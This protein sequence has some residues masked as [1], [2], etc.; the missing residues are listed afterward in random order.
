M[1]FGQYNLNSTASS[2]THIIGN[3]KSSGEDNPTKTSSSPFR[4]NKIRLTTPAFLSRFQ[5]RIET[6]RRLNSRSESPISFRASLFDCDTT[7]RPTSSGSLDVKRARNTVPQ[8][9]HWNAIHQHLANSATISRPTSPRSHHINITHNYREDNFY[10]FGAHTRKIGFKHPQPILTGRNYAIPANRPKHPTPP[11]SKLPFRNPIDFHQPNDTSLKHI[12]D[13]STRIGEEIEFKVLKDYFETTSYSEIV[14]DPDFKDYL[15][16]KNYGDIL[17]YLDANNEPDL[18]EVSSLYKEPNYLQPRQMNKSKSTG[19][20]YDSVGFYNTY[21][22]PD[23][24]ATP[25]E[26]RTANAGMCNSLS[27]LK[28]FFRK[29]NDRQEKPAEHQSLHV[30]KY[31]DIKK[32]CQLLF[33]ENHAFDE[34]VK[35][36]TL[37]KRFSEKKY[38]RLLDRFVKAKGFV[39]VEEYVYSK[40]GSI[41]DQ[42]VC[43][44]LA[45]DMAVKPE[46]SKNYMENIPKRYHVTKQQF[47]EADLSRNIFPMSEQLYSKNTQSKSWS[48]ITS[49]KWSR[50]MTEI[51]APSNRMDQDWQF[52]DHCFKKRYSHQTT[53]T[54]DI[55][56]LKYRTMGSV[57]SPRKKTKSKSQEMKVNSETLP[58]YWPRRHKQSKELTSKSSTPKFTSKKQYQTQE[59][60][61]SYVILTNH[62]VPTISKTSFNYVNFLSFQG[63]RDQMFSPDLSGLVP[64]ALLGQEEVLFGNLQELYTFHSDIFLKDLENCISTT[65]LV[66][67]CFVQRRQ[68]FCDLYSYYC[69][70]IPRSERLRETLVDTH[71]F[72]QECQKRLGHK[73]PLAA[74]LLK[75]VQRITK[76]QLLL[77]DLLK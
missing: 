77:K 64:P 15:S 58:P 9:N 47:L 36:A 7:K 67:L 12:L 16:R 5:R 27:R 32:F 65:E 55:V 1:K 28:R 14:N 72:L 75:P 40:F 29:S 24:R 48:N 8:S 49:S 26:P 61:K 19:N 69:Q 44:T 6:F 73:L 21:D 30:D 51:K 23:T 33:D 17:D 54:D 68:T 38:R 22:Y 45:S 31:T 50:D 70:N 11:K 60:H 18:S 59:R 35:S 2:S 42:T 66:A 56:D 76:Y 3:K 57:V 39:S 62:H 20:L 41:L 74:Y 53:H 4:L 63:Y 71:L 46:Y 52:S 25:K 10:R 37:G 43:S 34:K 13:S